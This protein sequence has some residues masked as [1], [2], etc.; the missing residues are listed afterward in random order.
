[1]SGIV[2]SYIHT[3][4]QIGV[5]VELRCQTKTTAM[6]SEFKTLATEIAMQIA[7][8]PDVEYIRTNDISDRVIRELEKQLTLEGES[9]AFKQRLRSISLYDQF[10]IRDNSITIEDLIKL[11]I[12]QLAEEITVRRF[13]RFAIE[14]DDRNPPDPNNGVPANPLPNSPTP[15]ASEAETSEDV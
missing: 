8:S 12:A 3:G 13:A 5:L 2:E 1:M 9:E 10:Y 4:K 11:S 7:A 6:T 14:S 15:L